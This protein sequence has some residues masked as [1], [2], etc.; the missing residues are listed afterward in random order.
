M[1]LITMILVYLSKIIQT[2]EISSFVYG[3]TVHI[4]HNIFKNPVVVRFLLRFE[5]IFT[6][7]LS[8]QRGKVEQNDFD[9]LK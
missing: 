5:I 1:V 6:I 4:L 7:F 9:D 2:F 3:H 8:F